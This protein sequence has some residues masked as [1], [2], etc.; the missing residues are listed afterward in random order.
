METKWT[1]LYFSFRPDIEY[2]LNQD[3]RSLTSGRSFARRLDDTQLQ[4]KYLREIASL[5][6]KIHRDNIQPKVS[7]PYSY[8]PIKKSEFK[9][10][11]N[12]DFTGSGTKTEPF[13]P[14]GN[15]DINNYNLDGN[16]H[17]DDV[18]NDDLKYLFSVL[19]DVSFLRNTVDGKFEKRYLDELAS[20]ILRRSDNNHNSNNN[21]NSN[22]KSVVKGVLTTHLNKESPNDEASKR[23][24]DPLASTIFKRNWPFDAHDNNDDHVLDFEKSVN[25]HIMKRVTLPGTHRDRLKLYLRNY[26]KQYYRPLKRHSGGTVFR[27]YKGHST[28]SWNNIYGWRNRTP[29]KYT[30]NTLVYILQ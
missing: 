9:S 19:E 25:S 21:N 18:V 16:S 15:V 20:D 13:S 23:F 24:L 7:Y 8:L 28:P 26:N 6:V 10:Y 3:K 4:K 11:N 1:F 5:L 29:S 27:L 30:N 14:T 22:V 17:D 2:T 12:Y